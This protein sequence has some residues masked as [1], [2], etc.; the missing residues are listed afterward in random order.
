MYTNDT[1]EYIKNTRAK[2]PVI[3]LIVVGSIFFYLKVNLFFL[4]GM[5]SVTYNENADFA[6]TLSCAAIINTLEEIQKIIEMLGAS[7]QK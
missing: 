4:R 1:M 2:K 3:I 6:S 5:V 7:A